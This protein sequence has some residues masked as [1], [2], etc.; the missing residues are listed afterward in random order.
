M[1]WMTFLFGVTLGASAVL[2]VLAGILTWFA[3]PF[4]KAA[5][6]AKTGAAKPTP[7]VPTSWPPTPTSSQYHKPWG[8]QTGGVD[9]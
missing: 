7:S 5:R 2:F 4:L 3:R 6:E 1:D 8:E 9:P